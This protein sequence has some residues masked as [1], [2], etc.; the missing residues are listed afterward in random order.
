MKICLIASEFYPSYGGIGRVFTHMCKV[1]KTRRETL[2]ILNKYHKGKNIFD[3]LETAKNY[4]LRDLFVLFKKRTHV[5]YFLLSVWK[6]ITAKKIKFYF[7]L[8][9][10]L[11]IFIKPNVLIKLV[12]NLPLIH[13]LLKKIEPDLIFGCT[14]GSVVLPL[15]FVLSKLMGKKFICSAHGTDFLVQSHYSIKTHFLKAID[16]II[17]SSNKMKEL[18]KK[19]NHLDDNQIE[20]IAC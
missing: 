17:V 1:F 14:C 4:N 9:M 19:I 20:I 12:R 5:F 13:T 18:I 2:Y 16:R 10:L 7:R 6:I 15:G 3:I 11:Y 8:N